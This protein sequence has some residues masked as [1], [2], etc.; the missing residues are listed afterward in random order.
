MSPQQHYIPDKCGRHSAAVGQLDVDDAHALERVL[1]A[2][3]ASAS[4]AV[5]VQGVVD[6]VGVSIL[7]NR[8]DL[9]FWDLV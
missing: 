6:V 2:V 9:K 1:S 8:L 7:W 4:S 3:A 5:T